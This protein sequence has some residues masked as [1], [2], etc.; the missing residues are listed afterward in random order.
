MSILL[1]LLN[2]A[3]IA[4]HVPPV[5]YLVSPLSSPPPSVVISN[6]IPSSWPGNQMKTQVFPF[7]LLQVLIISIVDCSACMSNSPTVINNLKKWKKTATDTEYDGL[8]LIYLTRALVMSP[9]TLKASV[10]NRSFPRL[11]C[12]I[13]H[14]I[15]HINGIDGKNPETNC[16][17]HWTTCQSIDNQS[18]SHWVIQSRVNSKNQSVIQ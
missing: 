12:F 9:Y 17:I 2:W 5:P 7:F 13:T 3:L 16:N 15:N 10:T 14:H 8:Y 18:V 6:S 11:L 4:T 1:K